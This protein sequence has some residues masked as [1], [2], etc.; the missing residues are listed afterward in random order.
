[1]D[2]G[3]RWGDREYSP[4]DSVG[5]NAPPLPGES[6]PSSDV[7]I[8]HHLTMSQMY[9]LFVLRHVV[10]PPAGMRISPYAMDP[11]YLPQVAHV[12]LYKT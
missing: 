8:L 10:R 7:C 11:A 4:S 6:T 3:D 9:C 12:H 5:H 1:M 2:V